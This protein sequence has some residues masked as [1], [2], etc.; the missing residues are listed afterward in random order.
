MRRRQRE[1]AEGLWRDRLARFRKSDLTVTEFCRREGVSTPSFYQWRKRLG[2]A[3]AESQPVRSA[4]NT[5]HSPFV[6]V[7]VF[8][9]MLAEIEF[10]NGITVRVPASNAEALRC[11]ILAGNELFQEATRC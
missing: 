1:S 9:S 3:A 11:V 4:E 5:A 8:S 6:P 10:P 7:K 2:Q